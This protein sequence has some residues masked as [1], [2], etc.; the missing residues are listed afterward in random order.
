[1]L[2]PG[3][4]FSLIL[5]FHYSQFYTHLLSTTPVPESYIDVLQISVIITYDDMIVSSFTVIA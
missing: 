3:K 4:V 2:I 5:F 1:M